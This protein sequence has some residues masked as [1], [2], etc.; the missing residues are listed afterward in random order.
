MT[1]RNKQSEYSKI[2]AHYQHNLLHNGKTE[3]GSMLLLGLQ[4]KVSKTSLLNGKNIK[5]ITTMLFHKLLC[6][7]ACTS[8]FKRV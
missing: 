6:G 1:I 5:Q 8:Q 4:K 3:Y 7:H 2:R